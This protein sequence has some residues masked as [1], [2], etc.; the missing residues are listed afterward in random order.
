MAMDTKILL[1]EDDPDQAKLFETVLTMTG[2]EVVT[3]P[4]VQAAIAVTRERA[5]DLALVD[6]DLP[7]I[8]GDAYILLVKVEF[9]QVKTLLFSNHPDV[10]EAARACG[11]DAWMLKTE[12]IQRLRNIVVEL[13]QAE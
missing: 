4:S 7:G 5:F 12:G 9:P 10:E 11:A 13:L 6:W 1:V 3:A 2:Y 8:A